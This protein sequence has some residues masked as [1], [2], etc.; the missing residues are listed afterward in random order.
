VS[1][2]LFS[3]P[4]T[5]C[6]VFLGAKALVDVLT[7][8]VPANV[9]PVRNPLALRTV[10][11]AIAERARFIGASDES[12]DRANRVALR[13]LAAGRSTAVAVALACGEL[14]DRRN[15]LLRTVT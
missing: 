7:K 5:R 14:T 13:E 4:G 1:A 12:R 10:R 6:D 3:F 15:P 11:A 2:R 9:V 8:P